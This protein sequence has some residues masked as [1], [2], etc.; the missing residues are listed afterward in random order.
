MSSSSPATTPAATSPSSQ[1]GMQL[2]ALQL[3]A[4]AMYLTLLKAVRAWAATAPDGFRL[5]GITSGGA[6]LAQR[7]QADLG[8]PGTAGVISSAMHRDVFGQ[9]LGGQQVNQLAVF[10]E[11]GIAVDFHGEFCR[12]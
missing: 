8:L 2:G 7:L 5:V 11:L 3:D 9:P 6:W 12:T 10:V 1:E 4:E